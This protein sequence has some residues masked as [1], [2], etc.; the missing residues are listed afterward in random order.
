LDAL[1]AVTAGGAASEVGRGRLATADGVRR[2]ANREPVDF[3][4]LE[5]LVPL[6]GVAA[7]APL[8]DVLATAESRGA[9]RGLLAQLAKIGPALAATVIA[10]LDDR[11][12]YVVRHLLTVLQEL[13]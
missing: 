12:W 8:L 9:R 11:R 7:A 5:R 6:V 4:T 1:D 3:K 2:V 10:P 13:G